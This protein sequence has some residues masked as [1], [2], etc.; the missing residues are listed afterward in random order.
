MRQLIVGDLAWLYIF[1]SGNV[2]PDL[3]FEDVRKPPVSRIF[4]V[5]RSPLEVD[6]VAHREWARNWRD[7]VRIIREVV[8]SLCEKKTNI[9]Y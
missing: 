2:F 8:K 7:F 3:F 4:S 1:A 6:D 5:F 9:I